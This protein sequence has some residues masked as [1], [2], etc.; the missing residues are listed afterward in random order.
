M[1]NELLLKVKEL[2]NSL[3]EFFSEA[4]IKL[5]LIKLDLEDVNPEEC[6]W[7]ESLLFMANIANSDETI[8]QRELNIINYLTGKSLS[9]SDVENLTNRD[10]FRTISTRVPIS[11]R[12]ACELENLIYKNGRAP[13]SDTSILDILITYFKDIGVL[14]A[15][16]DNNI[17]SEEQKRINNF[18]TSLKKYAAE[19]TLSPFFSY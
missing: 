2:Y 12:I 11:F 1:N 5:I 3:E 17:S 6:L 18:V 19:N 10:D 8:S 13:S 14:V 15:D 4:T 16:A 7:V 9:L